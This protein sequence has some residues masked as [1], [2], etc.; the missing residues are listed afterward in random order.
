MHQEIGNAGGRGMKLYS[1]EQTRAGLAVTVETNVVKDAKGRRMFGY[2]KYA[3][4]PSQPGKTFA[5]GE[6]T[7]A[8][9]HLAESVTMDYLEAQAPDQ[10]KAGAF[11]TSFLARHRMAKLGNKL[12]ITSDVLDRWSQLWKPVP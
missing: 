8:S 1:I 7:P 6:M 10:I 5:I 3:L 2:K 9:K 11:Q 12:E 4:P